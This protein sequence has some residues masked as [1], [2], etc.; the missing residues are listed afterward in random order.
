MCIVLAAPGRAGRNGA[1][2]SLVCSEEVPYLK[3]IQRL[4]GH[5]IPAQ[6]VAG[7]A[8]TA[9]ACVEEAPDAPRAQPSPRRVRQERPH[10]AGTAPRRSTPPAAPRRRAS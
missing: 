2:V 3:G 7:F 10:R 5:A 8:P 1:A 6:V 9:E 4:L